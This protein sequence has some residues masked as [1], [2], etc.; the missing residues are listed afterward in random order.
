MLYHVY[1]ECLW[2]YKI[3]E[4]LSNVES[5]EQSYKK[6]FYRRRIHYFIFVIGDTGRVSQ[7][8]LPPC[9]ATEFGCCNDNETEALGKDFLGCPGNY[10]LN[11]YLI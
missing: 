7:P 5:F 1:H 8:P 6:H 9:R 10:I 4:N 2:I 3:L 11:T